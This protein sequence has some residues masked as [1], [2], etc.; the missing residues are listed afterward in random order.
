M[1][2]AKNNMK[3]CLQFVDKCGYN[4][5]RSAVQS[6]ISRPDAVT[7]TQPLKMGWANKSHKEQGIA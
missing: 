1:Q 6:K 3:I 5:T 2:S 7:G 4:V